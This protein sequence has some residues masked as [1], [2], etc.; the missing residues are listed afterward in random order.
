MKGC[1]FNKLTIFCLIIVI[2]G[3]FVMF[4]AMWPKPLYPESERFGTYY[5][6]FNK[7]FLS[8]KKDLNNEDCQ[9]IY[10]SSSSVLSSKDTSDYIKIESSPKACLNFYFF[11][12]SIHKLHILCPTDQTMECKIVDAHSNRFL[13]DTC[14]SENSKYFC[15]ECTYNQY[16]INVYNYSLMVCWEGYVS[17]AFRDSKLTPLC[18][19]RGEY[20]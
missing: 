7:V 18:S 4:Y 16:G 6:P 8:F 11:S 5:N 14:A 17:L 12:D 20:W 9:Y 1:M 19:F 10:I 13:I 2:G 15:E 3:L